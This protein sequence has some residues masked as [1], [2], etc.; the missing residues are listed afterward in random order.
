MRACI[1][2]LQTKRA[3][4]SVVIACFFSNFLIFRRPAISFIYSF[5]SHSDMLDWMSAINAHIHMRYLAEWHITTD[6]WER[7]NV[8]TSFWKVSRILFALLLHS[9][10]LTLCVLCSV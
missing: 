1:L 3:F 9:Y 7:G 5:I 10:V 4:A 6:F 2:V 8:E